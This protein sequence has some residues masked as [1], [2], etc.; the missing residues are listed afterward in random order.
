ML[1]GVG[2]LPFPSLF[3]SPSSFSSCAGTF[4][5]ASSG[6][7]VTVA[8]RAP[9]ARLCR[10]LGYRGVSRRNCPLATSVPASGVTV[11][12][13]IAPQLLS[14]DIF[15][16]V[17]GCGSD[18]SASS[19]RGTAPPFP[20]AAR[21]AHGARPR[22]LPGFS[23]HPVTPPV[24][25]SR[26]RRGCRPG[27]DSVAGASSGR[28]F[29]FGGQ[30]GRGTGTGAAFLNCSPPQT[31]PG[32]RVTRIARAESSARSD[33]AS[34]HVA[35]RQVLCLLGACVVSDI[36]WGAL[37]PG[38][39]RRKGSQLYSAECRLFASVEY[40]VRSPMWTA[41]VRY[42]VPLHTARCCGTIIASSGLLCVV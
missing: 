7:G 3:H 5:E 4:S 38:Q 28:H 35:M 8:L 41:S 17:H 2:G 27:I 29:V 11:R 9:S 12:R 25:C 31:P 26:A 20:Q 23:P 34:Y 15:E 21:F 22:L 40:L 16:P 32:L 39:C 10:Q 37:R 42:V 14:A 24:Q 6:P 19:P 13:S 30:T 1:R 33:H 36:R 18:P